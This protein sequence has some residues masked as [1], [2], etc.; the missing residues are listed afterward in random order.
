MPWLSASPEATSPPPT[1]SRPLGSEAPPESLQNPKQHIL[2]VALE[3]YYHT[4]PFKRLVGRGHW[5]RF[6]TRLEVGTLRA[7]DLLDQFGARATFFALGWVADAAP[8][9]IRKV[10]DRG[11]EVA[12][13]GYY[14][15][16][17]REFSAGEF[18]DD[19]LRAREAVERASGQRVVGFRLAEGWLAPDQLWLLPLLAELD[20]A[21]DS[22]IKPIFRQWAAEPHRRFIHRQEYGGRTLWEVPFSSGRV[23]GVDLPIAGGNYFRQWPHWMVRRAVDR[24]DRTVRAPYVMYFHTWELDPAQPKFTGAPLHSRIRQYRNLDRMPA[25]LAH[26]LSSFRFTSVADSLR[27]QLPRTAGLRLVPASPTS[28]RPDPARREGV[29]IV[30]PCH[31]E[32]ASLPYLANTLRSVRAEL[33]ERYQVSVVLV[34]DGSRDATWDVMTQLFGDD[35]AVRCYRQPRNRGAAA[36]ILRGIRHAETPIVCSIDC[37]CSYDPHQL[38]A[39]LPLLTP[40]VDLV[41]ASPYHPAGAVR[42]VPAWRLALSR[43][44]SRLYRVVFRHQLATYTSCF[45]VYRRS[46]VAGIQVRR[47]GF[48]G[49]A[50]MLAQ[51]ER[52]G[53]RIVEHPAVL[54]SRLLG[55]SKM[56]VLRTAV[57]HLVLM[58]RLARWRFTGSDRPALPDSPLRGNHGTSAA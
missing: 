21:Y 55:H 12:T 52:A 58:L 37:D 57:G 33:A 6:E 42:N 30:V 7:L 50:E 44:A 14:H 43:V 40:D 4:T 5:Y 35:P 53:G 20:F 31:N 36:A 29:T 19:L 1:A 56:R 11:H 48:V 25:I 24:W 26:Y 45:R 8:E 3:D 38:T 34:D 18:R 49:V 15:R 51:L 54:E 2:T 46:A 41:T 28:L 13:R 22:S 32:A 9:L 16:A 23:L 27:L 17:L 10:V 47:G 39:M